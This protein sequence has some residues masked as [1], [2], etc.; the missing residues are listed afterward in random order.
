MINCS[1]SV[2]EKLIHELILK[3][4]TKSCMLDLIPTSITKQCLDDFVPLITF[5]VNAALSTCVVP[6]QFKQAYCNAT[7]E[8][9]WTRLKWHEDP[10]QISF[11]SKILEKV[12]LIQLKNHLSGNNL[13]EIFQSAYKQNHSTETAVLSVLD[14]LLCSRDERLVSL[15]ALLDLSAA[16]WHFGPFDIA[17]TAWRC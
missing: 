4:P 12:V 9:A 16:F 17:E 15:V 5:V 8:E 1:E 7:P 11:I 14:V 10:C 6:P 3:S 2:T 13:F